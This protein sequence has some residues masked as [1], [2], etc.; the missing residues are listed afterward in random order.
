MG[1]AFAGNLGPREA[2]KR[3]IL[4]IVLGVAAVGAAVWL[5]VRPR[6]WWWAFFLAPEEVGNAANVLGVIG[7]VG[8]VLLP[9]Y[10]V[11][12]YRK[13]SKLVL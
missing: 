8:T 9:V 11:Y 7:V 2:H 6:P 13:A 12:F 3:R 10:G 5:L 1:D 4:G